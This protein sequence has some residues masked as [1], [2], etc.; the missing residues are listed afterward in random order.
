MAEEIERLLER[1]D[2]LEERERFADALPLARRA[3]ELQP[4][5]AAA[6]EARGEM[7]LRSGQPEEAVTAYGRLVYLEGSADAWFRLG[8]AYQWCERHQ[9]AEAAF[10]RAASLDPRHHVR[11]FR[12][13]A[14]EFETVAGEVLRTLPEPVVEFL[15]TTGTGIAVRPL[16]GRERVADDHLDPH[17]LGY[18]LGNVYRTAPTWGYINPAAIEIYQLNIENWCGDR[19]AL[20]EEI[21]RTVLHEVGHAVGMDHA[22]LRADGYA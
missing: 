17:A 3:C 12:M 8:E 11:P 20:V 5:L 18:W 10:D 21:R 19:G 7:A 4:H 6:W 22:E 9:E 16:P 15:E 14:E 13:S 1:I 2:K